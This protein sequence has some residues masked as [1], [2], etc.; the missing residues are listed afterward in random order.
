[1][2]EKMPSAQALLQDATSSFWLKSA[3]QAALQRDPVDALNDALI[4]AATLDANLRSVFGLGEPES[5]PRG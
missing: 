4:L 5:S 1:M 3:L 2:N